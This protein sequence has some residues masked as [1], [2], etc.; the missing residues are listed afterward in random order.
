MIGFLSGAVTLAHLI[1]SGF[2]LSFWRKTRDRLFL[3]FAAAFLLF[4]MNQALSFALTVVT[5][6]TNLVYV[7]RVLGFVVIIVAIFDKNLQKPPARNS[8]P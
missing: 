7:L 1:G 8:R 2:F 3:A 5:E 4:A 6:P